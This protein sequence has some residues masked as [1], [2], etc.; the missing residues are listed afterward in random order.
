MSLQDHIEKCRAESHA[1][2]RQEKLDRVKIKI[3]KA[4]VKRIKAKVENKEY[5]V[6][7]GV[8]LLMG[9]ST[10][11]E[12]LDSD[13]WASIRSRVLEDQ[14][15]CR[16]CS[17]ENG[18]VIHIR[19]AKRKKINKKITVRLQLHHLNYSREVLEGLDLSGLAALCG[20]CHRRVEM[21]S[22]KNKRTFVE[23]QAEYERML[24]G[25]NKSHHI[26]CRPENRL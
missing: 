13:L 9:F 5:D 11:R 7:R 12:Y 18:Q 17:V 16:L 24:R 10:Y 19:K 20:R 21:T 1:R 22:C 3:E 15:T 25:K 8:L 14:T 4:K 26:P 6:R 23:S 2:W